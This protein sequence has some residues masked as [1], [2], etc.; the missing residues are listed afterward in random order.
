MFPITPYE[1]LISQPDSNRQLLF[2]RQNEVTY[3][4]AA[5]YLKIAH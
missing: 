1:K 5:K 3:H 2:S 4:Y